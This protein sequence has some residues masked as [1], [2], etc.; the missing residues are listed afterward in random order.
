MRLRGVATARKPLA[1]GACRAV[2]LAVLLGAGS[3]ATQTAAAEASAGN[4][5]IF[6][7]QSS[8][9]RLTQENAELSARV[10]AQE[11]ELEALRAAARK[12]AAGT[13]VADV[14]AVTARYEENVATLNAGLGRARAR[15]L[16]L[17]GKYRELAAT[18]RDVEGDRA[19]A[20]AARDRHLV[21]SLVCESRN[22]TLH[23]LVLGVLAD[24]E[25]R[26]VW[27]ALVATEPFAQVKRVQFENLLDAYRQKVEALYADAG[28]VPS[29]MP[30]CANAGTAVEVAEFDGQA[31]EAVAA[32]RDAGAPVLDEPPPGLDG[33]PP[34]DAGNSDASSASDAHERVGTD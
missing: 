24:V 11:A 14:A 31:A 33:P 28:G 30:A 17:A 4:A 23:A 12:T 26:G 16:E 18:L 13:A 27:D 9:Q 21:R 3:H 19:D 7:L 20:I 1:G 25:G 22:E 5:A 6:R 34:A 8:V 15:I 2:C 10:E 32:D 29:Q